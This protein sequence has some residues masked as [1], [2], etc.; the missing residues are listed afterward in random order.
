M[1]AGL[2]KM[3]QQKQ[4]VLQCVQREV[5]GHISE[6]SSNKEGSICM[7]DDVPLAQ[8]RDN[9]SAVAMVQS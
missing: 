2:N 7:V 6:V 1:V 8:L 9:R 5:V 4:Q 3:L